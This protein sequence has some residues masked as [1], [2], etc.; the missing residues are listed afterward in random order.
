VSERVESEV[1]IAATLDFKVGDEVYFS[2]RIKDNDGF[3]GELLSINS[4]NKGVYFLGMV[5]CV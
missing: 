3:T 1:D 2:G 5:S 4:I